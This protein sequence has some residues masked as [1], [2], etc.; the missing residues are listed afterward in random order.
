MSEKRFN[1]THEWVSVEADN[2]AT[3]GISD[4]AQSQLGEL[5]FVELPELNDNVTA[6]DEIAVVESVKTASDVYTPVSGEIV[7]INEALQNEPNLVNDSAENAG[8]L[9]KI[10]LSDK[11][12]YDALLDA[13]SYDEKCSH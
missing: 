9:Y 8:W 11:S 2:I 10:K 5:V 4:F 7:A 12:E 13:A 1:E 3:V 6:G